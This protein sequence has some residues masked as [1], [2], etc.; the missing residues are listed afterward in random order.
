MEILGSIS[1]KVKKMRDVKEGVPCLD[2]ACIVGLNKLYNS[3]LKIN[4]NN[5]N[6]KVQKLI[7]KQHSI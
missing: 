7:Y 4:K 5:N 3:L 2:A 1:G 6:N